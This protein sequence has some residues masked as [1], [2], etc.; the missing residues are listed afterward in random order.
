MQHVIKIQYGYFFLKY[1]KWG[2][3]RVVVCPSYIWDARSL[4]VKQMYPG[5]T[6]EIRVYGIHLSPD[7]STL[8]IKSLDPSKSQQL[9]RSRRDVKARTFFSNT[10]EISSSMENQI[11]LQLHI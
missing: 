10:S 8:K 2:V 6:F 11:Y 4:K 1:I 9:F 3:W 5:I 7:C